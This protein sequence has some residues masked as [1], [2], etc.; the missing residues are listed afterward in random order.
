M[1]VLLSICMIFTSTL[2]WAGETTAAV[3][4]AAA[5]PAAPAAPAAPAVNVQGKVLEVKNVGSYTYLRLKTNNGE[6]WAAVMKA[7]IKNGT[8]VTVENGVVMNNF[9]SKSL[10]RTFPV[11]LFGTLG[12]AAEVA[13]S[14]HDLGASFSALPNRKL[15]TI[16]ADVHVDKA[17]GADARTVVEIITKSAELKDKSVSV[18]GKVVKFNPGIMGKNW[19]HLRD[20]SGSAANETNDLLVTTLSETKVGALVT[21]KGT[22][23]TD[24]DFGSGYAYKVLVEEATLQ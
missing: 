20:G 24:K 18:R 2:V 21:A 12:G 22:V 8:T 6:L 4:P 3:S 17:S 19:V 16:V 10:K 13:P 5:T 1:K 14:S 23:R 7:Q 9:E 15:D 11:I